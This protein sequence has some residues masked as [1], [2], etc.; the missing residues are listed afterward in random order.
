MR[1]VLPFHEHVP[2]PSPPDP[3]ADREMETPLISRFFT[4]LPLAWPHIDGSE[5]SS[6]R[7]IE[8]GG[9]GLA[10]WVEWSTSAGAPSCGEKTLLVAS[11]V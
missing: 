5:S 3:M 9:L 1:R 11:G 2:R 7:M 10:G 8:R 4:K 6:H